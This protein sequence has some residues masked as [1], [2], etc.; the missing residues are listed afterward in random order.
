M[1]PYF[2]PLNPFLNTP[3]QYFGHYPEKHT[4]EKYP[5]MLCE[6]MQRVS[7]DPHSEDL[8]LKSQFK[9]KLQLL[10]G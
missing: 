4:M 9:L 5:A 2:C 3:K 6:C 7:K 8:L 1:Q 10:I